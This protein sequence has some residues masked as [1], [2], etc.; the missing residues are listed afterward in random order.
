MRYL[1]TGALG[2]IGAWSVR[3]LV[4]R[5]HEVVT[6]DLG[7]SDHRLRL[8]LSN[9]EIDALTRLDGDVRDLAA[10]ERVLEEHEI[11]A[12]IHLAALQVPFV[13]DDPVAGAQVN[14]VGTVN[15]LEAARRSERVELPVVYAS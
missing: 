8:A 13:R 4:D 3:A 1:V 10:L 12:V 15:I 11:G 2:A 7:G 9:D 14:V 6:Y 5:G